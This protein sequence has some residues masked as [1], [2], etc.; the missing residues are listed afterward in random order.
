MFSILKLTQEKWQICQLL[1]KLNFLQTFPGA[2]NFELGVFSLIDCKICVEMNLRK[3]CK[4]IAPY[5]YHNMLTK[6][7][8][9]ILTI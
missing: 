5:L 4:L 7:R 8:S 3:Y 1:L 9:I 6:L 2:E